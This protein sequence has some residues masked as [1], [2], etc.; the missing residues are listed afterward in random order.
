MRCD[1]LQLGGNKNDNRGNVSLSGYVAAAPGSAD[2][3]PEG[4]T[5]RETRHSTVVTAGGRHCRAAPGSALGWP[6]LLE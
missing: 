1:R 3:R 5:D 4:Q 2:R 6:T